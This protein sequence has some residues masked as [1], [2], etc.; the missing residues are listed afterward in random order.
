MLGWMKYARRPI[1]SLD[2]ARDPGPSTGPAKSINAEDAVDA[3]NLHGFLI[4]A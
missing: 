4:C 3:E 2:I 1:V